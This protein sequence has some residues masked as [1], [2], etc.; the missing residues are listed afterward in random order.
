M[1]YGTLFHSFIEFKPYSQT[2]KQKV[3]KDKLANF[4][5]SWVP[6]GPATLLKHISINLFSSQ[7]TSRSSTAMIGSEDFKTSLA[8]T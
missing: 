7:L 5:H 8:W 1:S 4:L 2:Y 6:I 3:K